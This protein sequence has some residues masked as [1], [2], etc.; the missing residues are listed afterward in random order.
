VKVLVKIAPEL[1]KLPLVLAARPENRR[2]PVEPLVDGYVVPARF[3]ATL[4]SPKWEEVVEFEIDCRE[5]PEIVMER[6][7]PVREFFEHPVTETVTWRP[8]RL[9]KAAHFDRD[10]MFRLVLAVAAMPESDPDLEHA[11]KNRDAVL[12][13][14]R[15]RRRERVSTGDLVQFAQHW[16]ALLDDPRFTT[17]NARV[18]ELAHTRLHLSLS[19]TRTRLDRARERGLLPK[20]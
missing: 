12:K 19:A 1:F 5:A 8:R 18:Q 2:I 6:R 9:G 16:R 17:D 13:L 20:S 15:P 14:L 7:L 11:A 10:E 3:K 4:E